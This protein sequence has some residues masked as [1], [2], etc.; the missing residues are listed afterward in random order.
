MV[1][2]IANQ[3]GIN[4]DMIRKDI[5]R[6]IKNNNIK[7]FEILLS[8]GVDINEKEIHYQNIEYYF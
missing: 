2:Q 1:K 8:K 3:E 5:N 4:K 7:G 6:S